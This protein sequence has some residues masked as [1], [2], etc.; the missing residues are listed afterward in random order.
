MNDTPLSLLIIAEKSENI[1]AT[2]WNGMTVLGESCYHIGAVLFYLN[3][4]LK[5]VIQK[6]A[7]RRNHIG[8]CW[9][10]FS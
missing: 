4:Q 5:F 8:F 6:L 1:L 2:H 9:V 7:Q 10:S 3:M